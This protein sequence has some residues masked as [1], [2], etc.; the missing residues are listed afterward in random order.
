MTSVA[1]TDHILLAVLAIVWCALHSWL[2]S[3]SVTEYL[4]KQLGSGYRYYRLFYNG[5]SLASLAVVIGYRYLIKSEIIFDWNDYL[6]IVQIAMIALGIVLFLL[7]TKKYDA[8]RFMGLAQLKEDFSKQG[9]TSSG[10]LD[11]SGILQVIRHP[12][13]A[14]LLLL[15][16]A[17]PLDMAGLVLNIVF[18]LYLLIGIWLE[19]K[20]LLREFGEAYGHYQQNVSMLIPIKWIKSKFTSQT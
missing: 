12:W 20:K 15:I 9:L 4:K 19:E 2:I 1:S 11:T 16:W 5:F 3:I 13:Y 14:A 7:G 6:R 17:M 18:T 8:R 10:E